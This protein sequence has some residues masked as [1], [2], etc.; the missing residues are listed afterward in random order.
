[1]KAYRSPL[2]LNNFFLLNHQY[3]VIQP[4]NNQSDDETPM[5][6]IVNQYNLEIDFAFQNIDNNNYQLFTK[7]GINDLEKPLPGYLLFIEGVCVFSFDTSEELT[8]K[9]KS[10][11]LHISGLNICINSLRNI[12]ATTTANGPIGKY[13]LPSINVNK[14]LTDKHNQIELNKK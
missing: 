3:H 6:E 2:I 13:T 10:D 5:S 9:D 14:L 4:P 8:E 11:L 12:I 7:I 1:M